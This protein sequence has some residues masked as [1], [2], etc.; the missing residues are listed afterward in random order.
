MMYIH[1]CAHCDRIHMLSGHKTDCPACGEALTELSVSFLEYQ[2]M[3]VTARFL[4]LQRC[5]TKS[6]SPVNR[7]ISSNSFTSKKP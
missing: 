4:I 2:N 5:R 7:P 6:K 3:D 1:Y